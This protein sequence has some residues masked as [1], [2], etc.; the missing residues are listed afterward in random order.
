MD[1]PKSCRSLLPALGRFCLLFPI[2]FALLP[3]KYQLWRLCRSHL[4]RLYRTRIYVYKQS[5]WPRLSVSK[6]ASSF[7]AG[8][9]TSV[10]QVRS[11][12]NS[13]LFTLHPLCRRGICT[14]N[15]ALISCSCKSAEQPRMGSPDKQRLHSTG[16]GG[17]HS[18]LFGCFRFRE[19][20]PSRIRRFIEAVQL[21]SSAENDSVYNDRGNS[22][23]LDDGINVCHT[24]VNEIALSNVIFLFRLLLRYKQAA[25]CG[26]FYRIVGEDLDG[27]PADV[28]EESQRIF[29]DGRRL[30]LS[31]P[32]SSQLDPHTPRVRL[33]CDLVHEWSVLQSPLGQPPSTPTAQ[34]TEELKASWDALRRIWR[35]KFQSDPNSLLIKDEFT[36]T[37]PRLQEIPSLLQLSSPP[38]AIQVKQQEDEAATVLASIP[39]DS[40][41]TPVEPSP[42]V[43][44][45]VS[46]LASFTSSQQIF[47][48]D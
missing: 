46:R 47:S 11:E 33:L 8:R 3:S 35:A 10:L 12:S 41:G 40:S 48:F 24:P 13:Y 9:K 27:W 29:V 2:S 44:A 17:Y 45:W 31:L 28:V 18:Y 26:C 23:W 43:R 25:H 19:A 16:Q 22:G 4:P 38:T 15:K 6:P 36:L 14:H 32:E 37:P 30:Y 34:P 42:V 7:L 39:L 1:P 20:I 21:S 5:R